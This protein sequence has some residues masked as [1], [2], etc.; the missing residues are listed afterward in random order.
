MTGHTETHEGIP[1][2]EEEKVLDSQNGKTTGRGVGRW[3]V[4]EG[5]QSNFSIG[6]RWQVGL[7]IWDPSFGTALR[8]IRENKHQV[9]WRRHKLATGSTRHRIAVAVRHRHPGAAIGF[10]VGFK[11]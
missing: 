3:C 7:P 11:T 6:R 1:S 8:R 9:R 2:G 5:T 10:G 4:M